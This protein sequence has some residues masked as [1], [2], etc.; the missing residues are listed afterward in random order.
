[1][2]APPHRLGLERVVEVY[3]GHDN[4]VGVTG[5][6]HVIGVDLVLTS[7]LVADLGTPCQ[8]RPLWSSRW[9]A[10]EQIWRGHGVALRGVAEPLWGDVPGIDH[11]RWAVLEGARVPCVAMGFPQVRRRSGFRD[12]RVLSG[13]AAAPTS[14]AARTLSMDVLSPSPDAVAAEVWA[15]LPGSAVLTDPTG[16]LAAVV[17]TTHALSGAAGRRLVA[18]PVGVLLADDRFRELTGAPPGPPERVRADDVR[19]V[20][21]GLLLPARE[22]LPS[23]CPDWRLLLPRHAVVPYTGREG[24][25]AALRA[26]AGEPAAL[27]VAVLT[28]RGGTGRTRLAGELCEELR[29][30][31]WDAGFLPLDTA[32]ATLSGPPGGPAAILEA[33]RPSLVVVES[34]EPSAP[35]VGELVRRLAKHGHNPRVRVLLLAREPGEAD[36]WRRLDTAS[37]GWLRR[38]NTTTV[39]LNQHPLT[40]NERTEH[41]FAAM[42]AFA[43]SRAALPTPPRL[44]DP[45]YGLPL[46]VHLAALL[47]LRGGETELLPAPTVQGALPGSGIGTPPYRNPLPPPRTG[48]STAGPRTAWNAFHP[49]GGRARGTATGGE[50]L[51]SRFLDRERD[52][53][54]TVWPTGREQVD[55]TTARQAVAL[56]TLAAPTPAE[57]PVLLSAVPGLHGDAQGTA[58]VADWLGRIFPSVDR[59]CPLGPDLVAEQALAETDDLDTLVLALHDHERRSAGHLV[60]MLDVLRLGAG[61]P[62]VGRA[63]RVLVTSRIGMLVAEATANPATRLGDL[64]NAALSLLPADRPPTRVVG[65]LPACRAV[66]GRVEAPLGLRALEV[67]LAELAVRHFREGG[68][69]TAPAGALA[70][71]SAR[72]ANVGRVGEAVVAAAE[73]V[74]IFAAAPPYE[75]AAGHAE[76]LFTLGACLL[77]AGEPG[78]ALRPAQEAATRFRILAEEAPR[79]AVQAAQAYHNL[80]C[81]LLETGRPA[82]A[83][84]AFEEA[85]GDDTFA[86]ALAGVLVVGTQEPVRG[87]SPGSG[88]GSLEGGAIAVVR[89]TP[90]PVPPLAVPDPGALPELAA[91]LAVTATAAVKGLAPTDRDLA[92]RLCL[93]AAWL[94]DHGRTSEAVA[95]AAEAVVRLRGLAGEEPGL[96]SMLAEAAGLLSRLHRDLDDLDPAERFAAEAV[97]SLRALVALEPDEHRPALAAQLL[98]LGELLLAD[99]R[100]REALDPLQDAAI[101]AAALDA[102]HNAAKARSGH[103]LGLCLAELGRPADAR[104]HLAAAAGLYDALSG[105]DPACLRHREEVRAAQEPASGPATAAWEAEQPW[106]LAL[107]TPPPDV[108]RAE[109]HL[110]DQRAAVEAAAAE[111]AGVTSAE[112]DGGEAREG[113]IGDTRVHAYVFAQATLARAWADAGRVHDGLVLA[114]QAAELLRRASVPDRPPVV[115]AG[116]VAGALGRTLVG[117][118]RDQEALPHL[119]TAVESYGPQAET[120]FVVQQELAKLLVLEVVALDRAG[121]RPDDADAAAERLVALCEGLVAERLES[122][123]ALAGALRLHAG[124][125]LAAGNVTGALQSVTRALDMLVPEPPER[126][127]RLTAT[128][129]ELSGLCHADLGERDLSA[130]ELAKGSALMAE[131]GPLTRDL[132]GVHVRALARLARLRVTGHGPTAGT[133]LYAQ[134]L[135]VRPLPHADVLTEVVDELSAHLR[136]VTAR[137]AA[138]LL[139]QLA[140]FAEALEREA[141]VSE[142]PLLHD[143]LGRCL[144]LTGVTAA[145]AVRLYKGL[146]AADA[147]HRH[148]LGLALAGLGDAGLPALEQAVDLLS[149][150]G[151]ALAETLN[152]YAAKLLEAGRAVE[153]LAHTERAA[154]LCDELDEPALAAVTYA[155]L[156]AALAVLD[157][158][159]AALEAV[160]WSLAEQERAAAEQGG[161]AGLLGVRAQAVQVRGQVLRASGRAQEALAHLVEAVRLYVR[162]ARP[163]AAAEVAGTIADDLLAAGRPEEA[164]EY[165]RIAATGHP[166]RTLRHALA[167]QRLVR[168]HM[169]LGEAREAGAL[170]E[171]LIRLA[172][173]APGELTYRAILADSL[174]QSSEL[175]PLLRPGAAEEAEERAREAI[176]IYDELLTTGMNAEALHV[177]RAGAGLTLAAALSLRDQ[178]AEAVGPLR[179]AV[180]ALERHAPANSLLGGLLSRA[181]L[182][183]GD[184]LMES[185]RPL[186]ASLVFH[187]ATQVVGDEPSGAVAHARLGFCQE[188]LG[189]GDAA[190]TALRV[191]HGLLRGLLTDGGAPNGTG[192]LT[193][194][195]RDVLRARLRL[196]EKSGRREET[197]QLENELR[198]I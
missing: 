75:E 150:D 163:A 197:A 139:P 110:A 33:V 192:E 78:S 22:P 115:L 177:S 106:M 52:Q 58:V 156:G 70:R 117:L 146:A 81:A 29:E 102:P 196:L 25:L 168:C 172:R 190:D 37:G 121:G 161:E 123:V 14:P 148:A 180:A 41:A 170:A 35:L 8:V 72:L 53:W 141:P 132:T 167:V 133:D 38:L 140:A 27:S 1:M 67:T 136:A 100:P 152:R 80:A 84:E 56:L 108:A 151:R 74:E 101:L 119:R 107:I 42:K 31:G 10:A 7:A 166:P 49:G 158:P 15:G 112:P 47:R 103:L 55:E 57:L 65:E 3:S 191:A 83:V 164:A 12:V 125:R 130:A 96:R 6:G 89:G 90:A 144:M 99:G 183:L 46:R 173:R 54:A 66:V 18:V 138:R 30:A 118:G 32:L 39:Q 97:R 165:A 175:L 145:P 126:T 124:L 5:S 85:G 114:T 79:Y 194:L 111:Q 92:H 159:Q 51:L 88:G 157:R 44:D 61:R 189:R 98:D 113:K 63:L 193:E 120:S 4:V 48:P 36:W 171:E 129:L 105:D 23:D 60:R 20:L 87:P 135:R 24:Q 122:P 149:E 45:E 76:A 93:L 131:E 11:V 162:L 178:P 160:T 147:R 94:G 195:L 73:A 169:M 187:R 40:L 104:A 184:A 26:W 82:E 198:T 9:A 153:A 128:C 188:E 59:L 182:M 127:R 181:M 155:Q 109:R 186:E 13:V 142:H 16:H 176:A 62:E 50:E 68:R 21:S 71:L 134:L 86:A 154:D 179:E 17:T 28:G 43:P 34:P 64:L 143:R 69:R 137:T 19:V 116:A 185:G 174:A 77:L 2:H 95:P 91:G